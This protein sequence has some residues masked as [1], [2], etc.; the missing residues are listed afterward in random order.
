MLHCFKHVIR[1]PLTVVIK[2][3]LNSTSVRVQN[4]CYLHIEQ[5][6]KQIIKYSILFDRVI[7]ISSQVDQMQTLVNLLQ[8]TI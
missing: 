5:I 4:S 7:V 8:R 6:K 3:V 1:S 2:N